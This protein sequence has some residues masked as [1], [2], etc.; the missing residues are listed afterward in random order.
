MQSEQNL[1]SLINDGATFTDEQTVVSPLALYSEYQ[2][3]DIEL[4]APGE[5]PM[6]HWHGQIEVNVPFDGDVEYFING[7]TIHLKQG[8]IIIFW[9]C[10]PHRLTN[11]GKCQSMAIFNLPM[12]LFLSLP[13]NRELINHVTHGMVVQSR[14]PQ[15]ICEFEVSRW[16]EE[17][18]NENEQIRQLA[19]DEIGLMIKRFGISGWD[20][21]L[22]HH[23]PK[24]RDN[25]ISKHAQFYVSQM[26]EFIAAN[27]DKQLT[28]QQIADHVELNQN[29][30]MGIFQRVMQLTMK[31][32]IVAMRINHA[33]VL[34][35]EGD[36]SI[37]DVA[38]TAGFN[39]S[40]RFY[41]TFSKF[42]GM[43][44]LQ[45]RKSSRSKF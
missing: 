37:L 44:P 6:S 20:P 10:V 41:D 29:Y 9:A 42:V 16:Q 17:T 1:V 30:A 24:T 12:H 11:I 19:L 33:R 13:I 39:S 35:S 14:F 23:T 38:L 32:Y 4:R 22:V 26:L 5:M 36:K 21:L 34:L 2:R 18:Q 15:Q 31:Q 27:H 43:T 28:I 7:E 40:S 8:H 45:Y 25:G 3:L